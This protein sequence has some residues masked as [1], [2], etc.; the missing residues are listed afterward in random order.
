MGMLHKDST[1]GT[2]LNITHYCRKKNLQKRNLLHLVFPRPEQCLVCVCV[3]DMVTAPRTCFRMPLEKST[4]ESIRLNKVSDLL[5]QTACPSGPLPGHKLSSTCDRKPAHSSCHW[6]S[7]PHAIQN[8]KRSLLVTAAWTSS[9]AGGQNVACG[10][11]FVQSLRLTLHKPRTSHSLQR[12]KP[13]RGDCDVPSPLH[14][15]YRSM[16]LWIDYIIYY[17]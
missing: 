2:T 14:T 16:H 11:R 4:L 10:D 6:R 15:A 1:M 9:S 17:K 3:C 13:S 8:R 5:E 7:P 12:R